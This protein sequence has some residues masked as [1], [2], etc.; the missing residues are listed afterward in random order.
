[1]EIAFGLLVLVLIAL[2]VWRRRKENNDW[3]AEERHEESGGWLDKRS[4]ERG[5]YGSLDAEREAERH[6]LNRQGRINDLALELRNYAFEYIPGFHQRSDEQI[7]AYNTLARQQVAVFFAMV[8][9]LKN[10]RE[11]E[12][13]TAAPPAGAHAQALQKILLNA[14]Y[15]QF[16]W[17]L[18]Q[19]IRILRQL[20]QAAG[21]I[22]GH[23][24]DQA[25]G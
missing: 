23:M 7:K 2:A 15:S 13:V 5:T 9:A 3:I 18:D 6:A 16:P 21:K 25:Q 24:A 20:D 8:E 1:M 10:G 14:A 11:P 12:P 19:E 4:G 22:A 17:L